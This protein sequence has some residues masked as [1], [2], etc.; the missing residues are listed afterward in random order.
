[1]KNPINKIILEGPDLSGKTT[2][3]N[4]LHRATD[5]KWNIQDRSALSMLVYAKL[6]NRPE[7]MHVERLNSEINNLN[8]QIVILLPDW[9]VI[10]NRFYQRGDELQNFVS[11][12]KVY[13]LFS[14]AAEEISSLPN[15]TV[16][17]NEVDDFM[18]NALIDGYHAVE[19]SSFA[20]MADRC[21]IAASTGKNLEKIGLSFTSYDDG[22]FVD[23]NEK[24]LHYEKEKVYYNSIKDKVLRKI[25]DELAGINEYSRIETTSSR[26]FIYTSD[27]CISLAHFMVRDNMLNAKYFLRS[28]NTKET[29]K[30]DLN[31]LKYLSMRVKESL[32]LNDSIVIKLEVLV[33]SAHVRSN[34]EEV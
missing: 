15:V 2:L 23:V 12:K 33:N 20:S 32:N 30:Y 18:I 26:R 27:T 29:L 21:L 16:L 3:Y 13:D 8:N 31:F 14:E 28:S 5:F 19:N 17:T 34:I 25:S 10:V 9:E 4:R 7:F 22:S 11:L 6:Y 24:D 1:M